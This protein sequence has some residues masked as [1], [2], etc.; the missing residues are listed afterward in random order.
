[1]AILRLYSC[2]LTLA[3]TL[4]LTGAA[5]SPNTS[6]LLVTVVDKDG[7]VL[8]GAAIELTNEGTG[9]ARNGLSGIDGTADFA[10]LPV[11]GIY[12]VRVQHPGFRP[13]VARLTLRAG[14]TAMIKV[15]LQVG[16]VD[17]PGIVT[18]YCTAEGVRGD[19]QIG[20]RLERT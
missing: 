17:N 2:V 16:G 14:E 19:A 6:S 15:L 12:L 8:P 3:I 9:A 18:V 1:F 7:A 13:T 4:A 11:N 5:Q 20:R 10:A